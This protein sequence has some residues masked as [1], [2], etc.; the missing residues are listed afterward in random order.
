METDY[1]R[2]FHAQETELFLREQ[3]ERARRRQAVRNH[4]E[5]HGNTF[6]RVTICGVVL[7]TLHWASVKGGP[8]WVYGVIVAFLLTV[9]DWPWT[10]IAFVGLGYLVKQ[11]LNL[12]LAL[13][14][15]K[16]PPAAA[17]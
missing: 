17:G 5:L 4:I 12:S 16:S 1:R 15:Y 8:L 7:A 11:V 9:G 2:Q 13:I 3:R 6:A 14:V 10:F